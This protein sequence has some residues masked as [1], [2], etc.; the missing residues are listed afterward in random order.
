MEKIETRGVV[1]TGAS[2]GIGRASASRLIHAGWRIFATVRKSRDGEKLQSEFGVNLTPVIMD[3]TDRVSVLAAAGK[4]SSELAGHGLDGLVNVAGIGMV[5]PIE[6][7]TPSDLQEI[8]DINVFGQIA[9]TQALL[10]LLRKARGRI[11]N[12]TSVGV[13]I[14][15]PFGAL[16]NASKAA[17]GMF[18]DT[19]RL[20][21][22]PFGIR[23]CTVEPGAI[24][25]PAVEKTLGNIEGVISSLP[26][27][28]AASYG[29][30]MRH[31]VARGYPREMNGSPPDVVARAVHDALTS[32]RPKTRYVV[33]KHA[34]ILST[35]PRLLPDPILDALLL[36]IAGMPTKMGAAIS[37]DQRHF[38]KRAAWRS[39]DGLMR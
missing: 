11:V 20:E 4:L 12:I 32:R 15:I 3:V 25:T 39:P 10:P 38:H 27:D 22:R 16:L 36:R 33:G 24:R 6:Y 26:A 29:D 35:L 19:L 17:F 2:S 5:R 34:R 13:H 18:S 31:F 23:V 14:P 21:L 9:V 7:A 8:F 30:M 1:I 28:G 37:D